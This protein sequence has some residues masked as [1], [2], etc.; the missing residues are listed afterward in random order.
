MNNDI[1]LALT[2]DRKEWYRR[3]ID[4]HVK[5]VPSMQAPDGAFRLNIESRFNPNGNARLQDHNP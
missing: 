3:Q 2:T 1:F 4:H 5:Q